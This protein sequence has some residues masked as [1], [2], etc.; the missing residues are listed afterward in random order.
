MKTR[1]FIFTAIALCVLL[2]SSI[3]IK[4]QWYPQNTGTPVFLR[5]VFFL[6]SNRGYA[7]GD[8]GVILKTTDGGTSWTT[9]TCETCQEYS[10]ELLSV[11]FT[12]T[13]NGFAVGDLN[14]VIIK[15][16]DGGAN[17]TPQFFDS[18]YDIYSI[19]FADADTGFAVGTYGSSNWTTSGLMLKTTDGGASWETIM[20]YSTNFLYSIYFVDSKIGFA[21]GGIGPYGTH[22][23][24]ILKTTDGGVTWAPQTSGTTY[25]LNSVHFVDANTGYAVG[26]NGTI[27]KTI[28]GGTN[29]TLQTRETNEKLNSVYFSDVNNGCAV[30][31][32]GTILKTS[33]GGATWLIQTSG[34]TYDLPS[35][36]FTNANTGYTVGYLG[37]LLKTTNGGWCTGK[38][39]QPSGITNFCNPS[40][41]TQYT[42]TGAD[43]ATSYIWTL[44]PPEAGTI[45]G[46]GTT[47][48]V[49]WSATYNGNVLVNVQ[50]FKSGCTGSE[51]SSLNVSINNLATNPGTFS[52]SLPANG[53]WASATP[54]FKW[55]ASS[56]ALVYRLYIDGV[57]KKDN[58]DT[59]FYNI[60]SSEAISSGM[61][62][63][64]VVASN[65]CIIQS[66]ETWSFNVDATQPT[67]FNLVSPAENSWLTNL[68]PVFTWSASS[69][70][71]SGLSKYQL[72]ID[73]SLNVDN[74]PV[75]TVFSTPHAGLSNGAH[76]WYIV[77]VDN[78]GNTINSTQTRTLK[79]DNLPPVNNANTCLS[80]QTDNYARVHYNSSLDLPVN[81]KITLEA[82][83]KLT[84]LN[85][86]NPI[87]Y[88]GNG[89]YNDM[90]YSL[91]IDNTGKLMFYWYENYEQKSFL[92]NNTIPTGAWTHIAITMDNTIFKLY[93]N[94]VLDTSYTSP[95]FAHPNNINDLLIGSYD[96]LETSFSGSIDEIR[97]WNSARTQ[98]EI[99]QYKDIPL[100]G[101]EFGLVLYYKANE[102][103]GTLLKDR[104]PNHN[105]GYLLASSF[106]PSS[107]QNLSD[108]CVLKFPVNDQYVQNTKPAFLW[109]RAFDEGS[110]FRMFQLYI[111]GILV[112]DSLT[113]T[114]WTITSPLSYGQHN[115]YLVGYDSLL[116]NQCT[117][118]SLF[119][120]DDA[121]PNAFSLISPANNQGVALPTPNLSWQ[122]ATDSIGGSGLG[123]YQLWINGV[124]NR[125]SIPITQ[126][127]VAPSS[128]LAQGTYT[129]YIKVF[130]N[131]G[132]VRQS[133][134]TWTFYVDWVAP[135]NF[136]IMEPVDNSTST[137]ARPTFKWHHSS[138]TGSG[139]QRYEICISGQTPVSVLSP[140]TSKLLPFDLPNN[141]YTWYVKA[142][143][144]AGNFTN[145]S[146]TYTLT[147]NDP[148]PN[149]AS[150]PTGDSI[151]C[152]NPVNA[153]F[154]TTGANN[155]T[156]YTWEITPS[157][158]GTISGTSLTGTVDWNNT[159][160]GQVQITV[161]GHNSAG[162]GIA[163]APYIVTVYP[164]T[165]AGSVSGGGSTCIGD[166]TGTLSLSGHNGNIIKWQKRVNSGTWIDIADTSATY[167]EAPPTLGA[168]TYRA[169]VKSGSCSSLFSGSATVNVISI[170]SGEGSINGLTSVCKGTNYTYDVT[171]IADATS[172][173][174]TLPT[175]V[176]GTSETNSILVDF[177][178]SA[179]S[180][181]ILVYGH[182]SCGDGDTSKITIT[183]EN[184]PA[185]PVITLNGAVL[186]S[187][188]ATGNTWFDQNGFIEGATDQN[189]T[190]T[191]NG[192]YYDII[193]GENGCSSLP[194]NTIHIT[195][196][197]IANFE[198][199]E[200]I[201][202]YPNPVSDELIIEIKGNTK[203]TN[204][205]ISNSIGQI[206]F[207]GNML[208]K[209]IVKTNGFAQ[210]VYSIKFENSKAF[211]FK[212]IVKE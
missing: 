51:T 65:G 181:D 71:N 167:R 28:N 132:N 91:C 36:F 52:L 178:T 4:A 166:S 192:D 130:D 43:S 94:G 111:D 211:E 191:S 101:D 120:V 8:A 196:A 153:V 151:F 30:G 42:T 83:V 140:D 175:G 174:W 19:Y 93:I 46:T 32:N 202:M 69:D 128:A 47:S 78:V 92:S 14:G 161:K 183:V 116:N 113:D 187:N 112:K 177:G 123:K 2:F 41:T 152:I 156:S 184:I 33:D 119:N 199:D 179:V 117:Y 134:Q 34:N 159:F 61:H 53:A 7:V 180:G 165:I 104:S 115:W 131:V 163:S 62:T 1:S 145:S 23:G 155:A 45:S 24:A 6:D 164:L 18:N 98:N 49:T 20:D 170:P 144:G 203:T 193:K 197:G 63:W 205:E 154:T 189:Y 13:T 188:T 55:G 3:T 15:T 58:I 107:K 56:N 200:T 87:I 85:Y 212:K 73:G 172:Y 27:L 201:I 210:G 148:L 121:K 206:V 81:K 82:W 90:P 135:A 195:N 48:T 88:K 5:S 204:F 89:Y 66:N 171:G 79:V 95:N 38:P 194:S 160:T 126:T 208:D 103:S 99:V 127:T 105:N 77:A 147:V 86:I 108:L 129:W 207:K 76:T 84:A 142:Y 9:Q 54:L 74:I 110:G 10:I 136:T 100:C 39:G 40:N 97:I 186:H 198:N 44:D 12:D 31:Y 125:D 146:N 139:I 150:T 185:T 133:T 141:T 176:T 11:F 190:V 169:E 68:L 106:A 22:A 122:A 60:Q 168:W 114:T 29:W 64:H 143:D 137:I 59:N 17:W 80:F 26:N 124:K 158:A 21:V 25:Y 50:G 138:D 109:Y 96:T 182:N 149:Q 102:S 35:V 70:A 16:T 118:S 157:G 75:G 72:W 37:L 67:A 209:T 173:V 57:L 162:Y